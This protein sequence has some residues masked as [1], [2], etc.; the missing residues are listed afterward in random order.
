MARTDTLRSEIARLEKKRAGLVSDLASAQ[1]KSNDAVA[2]ARR[3]RD[4][5]TKTKS[6][7]TRRTA[8]AAA[9]RKEKEAAA[10]TKT[11]G[12]ISNRISNV[13]K[14][15][16]TKQS[17][18]RTA[19]ASE[20]RSR[21][22]DSDRRR[23]KEKTHAREISRLTRPTAVTRYVEVAAPKPEKLR[24]LYLTANP[25]ATET[26]VEHP[27]GSVETTG[28]WLR[29]DFE[30]RQVKDMLRKSKYRDLVTI[31]HLPAATSMDLLEGLNDHRPHVVHFSGHA[32]SWG[33]LMEDD[34][35]TQ[36]GAG[37]DFSTLARILGA[38][39]EPPRLVVLNACNSL[40]GAD[41][42]LQTVPTVIGMSDSINDA[43]AVTFAARFYS[44]IASAQSVAT[45]V[46]QAQVAM[47][48]ASLDGSDLPELITRDDVDASSLV[49][50]S[51]PA[52]W[53]A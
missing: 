49:L 31:E 52:G 3:K 38:T 21:D 53:D 2:Q 41:D 23:Q 6:D 43:S 30:V 48:A 40:D 39:D 33:L 19:V 16:A 12:D 5:A 35:G 20:E 1:K 10:A 18:L 24:V 37:L 36:D 45:A 51:V 27:D 29:V 9:E 25:E 42:L 26:T 44:A 22:K 15:L 13:D 28:V 14:A 50:V 8:M 34:E 46:E 7:S 47:L 4:Q 17:S 11:A 32:S